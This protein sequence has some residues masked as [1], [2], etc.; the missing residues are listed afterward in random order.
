MNLNSGETSTILN[1]N[2][3]KE[4]FNYTYEDILLNQ[5]EIN[6][7]IKIDKKENIEKDFMDCREIDSLK[8]H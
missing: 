3:L 8:N 5:D 2:L 1:Y 7:Y 6:T 4:P